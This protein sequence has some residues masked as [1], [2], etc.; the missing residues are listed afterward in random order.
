M[1]VGLIG[2][3]GWLLDSY[4]VI[5]ASSASSSLVSMLYVPKMYS[6]KG[7]F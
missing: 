3:E 6:R 1:V 7:V 2:R 4:C 5:C